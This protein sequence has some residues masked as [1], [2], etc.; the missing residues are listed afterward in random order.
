MITSAVKALIKRV[1]KQDREF[2][3]LV[4]SVSQADSLSNCIYFDRFTK[5]VSGDKT[6]KGR[7]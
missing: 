1:K 7:S 6:K 5:L 4:T 2:A 3:Q